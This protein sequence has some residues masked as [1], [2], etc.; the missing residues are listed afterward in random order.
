VVNMNCV[1]LDLCSQLFSTASFA[2]LHPV[3][4]IKSCRQM[5]PSGTT[6]PASRMYSIVATN[7]AAEGPRFFARGLV[8]SVLRAGPVN[9]VVFVVYE[10][11]MRF[12]DSSSTNGA[13]LSFESP[14][15]AI[16]TSTCS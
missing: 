1:S 11:I 2:L 3:D 10:R 7:L 14:A 6:A 8:P 9:A 13:G 12:L 16:A 4:V 5:Q 15:T